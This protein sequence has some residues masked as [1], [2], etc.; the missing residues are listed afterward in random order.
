MKRSKSALAFV[1]IG[2]L[3]FCAGLVWIGVNYFTDRRGGDA[4]EAT[5]SKLRQLMPIRIVESGSASSTEVPDYV[6]APTREMPTKN[7][8]GIDYIAQLTIPALGLDLPVA[9]EWSYSTL[10]VS[11]CRYYGS[12]YTDNLVIL[13]HNYSRHFGALHEL[14]EGDEV[15]ITDMDGNVFRYEVNFIETMRPSAVIDMIE[16]DYELSLFTCTVGGKMRV[17]ARC[18]LVEEI[19]LLLTETQI[20]EK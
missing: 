20:A 1:V 5:V 15:T 14:T 11:P 9:S 17:C 18:S 10:T 19:P 8:D 13:A 3:L 2:L 4:A 12:A 6:M 7:V 16:S